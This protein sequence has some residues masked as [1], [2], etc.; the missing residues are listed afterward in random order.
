[1]KVF[2]AGTLGQDEDTPRRLTRRQNRIPMGTV[3]P[4]LKRMLVKGSR[5][6]TS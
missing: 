6:S 3:S 4:D 5:S 2:P 1:M